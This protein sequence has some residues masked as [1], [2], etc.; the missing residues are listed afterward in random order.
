[1]VVWAGLEGDLR[2]MQVRC[3][4]NAYAGA[5]KLPAAV[6][7]LCVQLPR[8]TMERES[9]WSVRLGSRGVNLAWR[10]AKLQG[11]AVQDSYPSLPFRPFFC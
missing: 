2:A 8:P 4:P 11:Q 9:V 10:E 6:P 5:A 7:R 1:M 3:G